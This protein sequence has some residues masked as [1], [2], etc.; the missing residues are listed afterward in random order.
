MFLATV[1]TPRVLRVPAS[2][3]TAANDDCS[4]SVQNANQ[5]I[6]FLVC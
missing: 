3:R 2:D 5:Y 6:A 4:S 1:A